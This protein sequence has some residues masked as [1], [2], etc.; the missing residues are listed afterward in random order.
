[1]I[2][3]KFEDFLSTVDKAATLFR[4]H[5]IAFHL[6]GGAAGIAHGEPRLTQDLDLV[7]DGKALAK[8]LPAFL[9]TLADSDFQFTE[10][11]VRQAITDRSPFQ[12]LDLVEVL[13]LD[14]YPHECVPG[15]L[16]RTVQ[17]PILGSSPLPIA[18]RQDTLVAK[19]IWISK[20]SHKSRRDVRV[21]YRNTDKAQRAF[22]AEMAQQFGLTDLLAEVL[23]EPDE[24]R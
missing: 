15:E 2:V 12:L 4:S 23:A 16:G 11:T 9:R 3:F 21:L 6:V 17:M 5:G 20:G 7:I 22:I 18:S 24:I 1:M 13:K 14:V 10:A 8:H 19:L